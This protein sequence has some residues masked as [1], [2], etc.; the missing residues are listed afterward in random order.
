MIIS[1]HQSNQRFELD[2]AYFGLW[3]DAGQFTALEPCIEVRLRQIGQQHPPRGRGVRRQACPQ[4]Q[5]ISQ[6]PHRLGHTRTA[7]HDHALAAI[8]HHRAESRL[9]L[10]CQTVERGL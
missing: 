4:M 6:M 1:P 5:A 2:L 7:G 8:Q 10:L 9:R 3:C